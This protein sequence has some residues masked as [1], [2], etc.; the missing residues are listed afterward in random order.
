MYLAF[1]MITISTIYSHKKSVLVL[2]AEYILKT[3]VKL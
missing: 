1:K 2:D 3:Q